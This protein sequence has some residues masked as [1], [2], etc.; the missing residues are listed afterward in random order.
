MGKSNVVHGR[1]HPRPIASKVADIPE[2]ALNGMVMLNKSK[3]L[4]LVGDGGTGLVLT[5]NV[6][7]GKYS[8]TIED[9]T[10]APAG[11]L[12]WGSTFITVQLGN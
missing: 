5:L 3:G 11:Q 12:H 2:G 7:T 9:P 10:M 6:E 4:V 1:V 8:K